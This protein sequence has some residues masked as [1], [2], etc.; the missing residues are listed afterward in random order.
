MT[1]QISRRLSFSV[2]ANV[3]VEQLGSSSSKEKLPGPTGLLALQGKLQNVG[4]E[5]SL[6]SP[7]LEQWGCVREE[8]TWPRKAAVTMEGPLTYTNQPALF[9]S[10]SSW[11]FSPRQLSNLG[12]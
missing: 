6:M 8:P 7:T 5:P 3:T 12:R 4:P 2:M 11:Y 9:N 1:A 10:K